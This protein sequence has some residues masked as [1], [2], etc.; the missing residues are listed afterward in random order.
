MFQRRWPYAKSGA[1]RIPGDVKR[2]S[3]SDM[4][5]LHFIASR[6]PGVSAK[7]RPLWTAANASEIERAYLMAVSIEC[8][9]WWRC[10][11]IPYRTDGSMVQFSI[12]VPVTDF[13]RLPTISWVETA[14]L[15]RTLIGRQEH[16]PLDPS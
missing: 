16:V 12:G 2:L 7:G 3:M 11:A 10:V 5:R 14:E 9:G 13:S 15:V 6:E 1:H 8:S 4:E